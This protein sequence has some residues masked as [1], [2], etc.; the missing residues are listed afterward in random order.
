M[1]DRLAGSFRVGGVEAHALAE[2]FGTPLFVYDAETVRATYRSVRESFHHAPT[3]I[4]FA[5]VCNPNLHL[6]R[7]L[8]A[9][10]AGLHAN[11]PGDVYCG[12]RAGFGSEDIVFSGSNVGEEDLAYLVKTGVHVNVDSLDDLERACAA[13]LRACGLRVHVDAVLPES[14]VGLREDDLDAAL[15]LARARGVR[16]TALHVYCGTHGQD[17]TRYRLA[18]ARLIELARAMP[19]IDCINLGGGFGY[20]YHDPASGAFPFVEL[21]AAADAALDALERALN[22]P[23]TLRAEPGR[24][25]VA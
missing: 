3:R 21:A 17:L 16:V 14:R 24:A 10:G 23:V 8:R 7:L 25:L 13:G 20:D 12:L 9:E 11:T 4:H 18:L 19:E 6:L 5:A 15:A 1:I 2:Q 22:R